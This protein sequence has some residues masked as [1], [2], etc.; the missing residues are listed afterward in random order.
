MP[1]PAPAL[2]VAPDGSVP[3]AAA[4]PGPVADPPVCAR[5]FGVPFA[6]D[7]G[8]KRARPAYGFRSLRIRV[9][10]GPKTQ[11][12]YAAGLQPARIA[13]RVLGAP[14]SKRRG[15]VLPLPAAAVRGHK[16]RAIGS[17]LAATAD[18]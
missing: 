18:R 1:S 3:C 10:P 14:G 9:R 12:G 15:G 16:A 4:A 5:V 17:V 7:A 8:L 11:S 13:V 2:P 6:P